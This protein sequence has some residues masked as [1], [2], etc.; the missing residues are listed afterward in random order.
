[1]F[2][3]FGCGYPALYKKVFVVLRSS[4]K[5]FSCSVGSFL[6]GIRPLLGLLRSD[7]SVLASGFTRSCP[8][9]YAPSERYTLL[10]TNPGFRKACTPGSLSDFGTG[11]GPKGLGNLA[12]A[13]AWV[14]LQ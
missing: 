2:Y 8:F 1:M 12:Q 3:K 10:G 5:K 13:L 4:V 7:W 6:L 14:A 11:F 9:S